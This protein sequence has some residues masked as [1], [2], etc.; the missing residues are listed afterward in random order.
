M[1]TI[2]TIFHLLLFNSSIF[3]SWFPF[4]F[5]LGLIYFLTWEHLQFFVK[6][7]SSIFIK[8]QQYVISFN[9]PASFLVL[10]V[11]NKFFDDPV[12]TGSQ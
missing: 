7:Q 2:I 1:S 4:H 12:L 5:P 8:V 6:R 3:I 10:A 11:E 9:P